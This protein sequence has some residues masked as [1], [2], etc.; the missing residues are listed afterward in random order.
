MPSLGALSLFLLVAIQPIQSALVSTNGTILAGQN[1]AL[2]AKAS[3]TSSNS[4]QGAD[5]VNDGIVS[6]YPALWSAE[7]SAA[8]TVGQ[9]VNLTWGDYVSLSSCVFYD[10]SYLSFIFA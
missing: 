8:G 3:S 6:G 5:K 4:G 1:L 10:V 2:L 9:A 7:W